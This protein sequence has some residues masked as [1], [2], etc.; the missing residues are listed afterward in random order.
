MIILQDRELEG[1]SKNW[2]NWMSKLA[3]TTCAQCA[4]NIRSSS[5]SAC[6]QARTT[7]FQGVCEKPRFSRDAERQHG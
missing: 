2:K 1:N 5:L 7:I 6:Q 3:L 4:N